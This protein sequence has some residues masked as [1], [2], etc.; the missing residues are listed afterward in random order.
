MSDPTRLR[1][2][3]GADDVG[4]P[5]K[6]YLV[7]LLEREDHIDSVRD[8]SDEIDRSRPYP[9]VAFRVASA[10]IEGEIDRAILICGTGIGM[11]ISATKVPGIRAAVVHD[12][13]SAERSVLS[14]DCQI[15][16]LGS[17]I[18]A[19]VHA[20]R[21]VHEWLGYRFDPSSHS[22]AKL[23]VIEEFERDLR[24]AGSGGHGT[25]AT[26]DRSTQADVATDETTRQMRS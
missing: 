22:A 8:Y 12:G 16:A 9:V 2:G 4:A 14:N 3:I 15:M 7:P 21:L 25:Q 19:P 6:E 5:L 18:I 24:A 13:Y 1:L 10:V 23:G 11:C 26:A 20:H 17:R